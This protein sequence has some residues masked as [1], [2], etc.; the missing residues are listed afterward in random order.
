MSLSSSRRDED[1]NSEFDK[2]ES[3]TD[4]TNEGLTLHNDVASNDAVEQIKL[5]YGPF[6]P[7][8]LLF[9]KRRLSANGQ[10]TVNR[11]QLSLI[12]NLFFKDF[13]DTQ[14]INSI[15][16]D[17]YIV[18]LVAAK[19]ILKTAGMIMLPYIISSRVVRLASRKNIN[20]KELTKLEA[21]PLWEQIK[22]KYRNNPDIVKYIQ[23]LIASIL[24]SEFEIID[25][26]D[27]EL[28]GHMVS[29]IPEFICEE[30][31]EYITLI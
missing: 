20:K 28:D 31:L 25:M 11:F 3:F 9:Y 2:F 26:E 4:K 23:S 7:E 30:M 16:I 8:E 22:Y 19:R 6:D 15:N 1:L 27:D 14:S 24:S 17:D 18:L 12:F 21:S 10:C 13:E 5:M 29:V